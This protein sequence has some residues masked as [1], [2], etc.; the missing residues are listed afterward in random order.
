[1]R[2]VKIS[3]LKARLSAHL[4]MVRAGEEVL[5]CDRNCPVA[6]IIPVHPEEYSEQERRLIARGVLLPPLRRR[7]WSDPLP[8]PQGDVPDEVMKEIWRREREGR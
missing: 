2:T 8:E 6:R 3:E 7:R 5:V 1:M 4:K